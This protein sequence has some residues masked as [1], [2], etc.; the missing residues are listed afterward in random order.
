MLVRRAVFVAGGYLGKRRCSWANGHDGPYPDVGVAAE[1]GIAVAGVVAA[2]RVAGAAEHGERCCRP[3]HELLDGG[4]PA[5]RALQNSGV[6]PWRYTCSQACIHAP[7]SSAMVRISEWP[8]WPWA[9]TS[10]GIATPWGMAIRSREAT[11]GH[12]VLRRSYGNDPPLIDGDGA[13]PDDPALLVHGDHCAGGDKKIDHDPEATPVR[14]S[15]GR[16]AS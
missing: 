10:P 1:V 14:R 16:D 6:A 7:R 3:R 12:Q 15:R 11:V 5:F 4:E 9:S 13:I 2:D 8:A